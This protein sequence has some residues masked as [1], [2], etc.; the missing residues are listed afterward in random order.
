MP[1][2]SGFPEVRIKCHRCKAEVASF[3]AVE[4]AYIARQVGGFAWDHDCDPERERM[5]ESAWF[6]RHFFP[7]TPIYNRLNLETR[8]ARPTQP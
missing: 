2:H 7:D 1:A 8:Y 5:R 6:L 3:R 4:W